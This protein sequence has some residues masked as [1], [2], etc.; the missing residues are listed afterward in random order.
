MIVVRCLP[1]YFAFVFVDGAWKPLHAVFAHV[2]M[3]A[4]YHQL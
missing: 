4:V 1:V 3:I 2:R